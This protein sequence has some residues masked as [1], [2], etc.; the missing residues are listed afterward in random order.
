MTH[1][2]VDRQTG[3]LHALRE[4][5]V[6][7]SLAEAL[8][9]TRALGVIDLLDR[10]GLRAAYAATVLKRPAHRP[11]FDALFDL[12]FPP[13]LGEPVEAD[14]GAERTAADGSGV[15]DS[16]LAAAPGV[17]A[18][19]AAL[20][21]RLR[22]LLLA[23]DE[24][25][26]RRFARTAVREL[27]RAD[28]AP[29]RQAWF[30]YRVLRGLSPET[31]AVSLLDAMLA[32]QER[33]G[34]AEAVARATVHE[35]VR[36]FSQ[37]VEQEVRRRQ[38][39]DRGPQALSRTA[40]P[41]LAESVDFLRASRDDMAA[42]R[43]QVHPLARRLATRLSARRRLGRTGRLDVR[44]TVR[45]SLG[46]GGVPL[47]IRHRPRRPHK[48]ELTV[49]C[50]LSGSVAGFAQFT[51]MLAYALSEQF[52]RVR[53]FAFVDTVDEVTSCFRPGGDLAEAL[54]RMSAEA[55]LVRYDGHSDYGHSFVEF[56]ARYPDAVGPRTSLL[57]LG[58]AR[59]N[60]RAAQVP[61][62][63][64]LVERSRSAYWLNPEPRVHWGSGDSLTAAYGEVVEMVE[65]RNAA[66]LEQFVQ[67]LLPT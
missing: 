64:S 37:M 26:L 21:E 66:Q 47:V 48:P 65:V 6:A 52:T 25:A 12:W 36:R 27:G 20:R 63:R 46:T 7:I 8:D 30:H 43:R 51:L 35:R 28:T 17:A 19:K 34:L 24:Q 9:A 50:D 61:V 2:L 56:A 57:V 11:A 16:G 44:R 59:N 22:A 10:E 49:L 67:R 14:D 13:V 5:G 38:A 23:G 53:A 4:A 60:F 31:L 18:D 45:T 39:E 55:T 1:G 15:D 42:L 32:G 29:G 58:D 40:V 41:P 54:A 33:G 62:L 3:F